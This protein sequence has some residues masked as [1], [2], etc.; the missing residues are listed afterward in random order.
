M[1]GFA[2]SSKMDEAAE[3]NLRRE[4][5][6]HD[7]M[8][9]ASGRRAPA[10]RA[11]AEKATSSF[12]AVESNAIDRSNDPGYTACCQDG[13]RRTRLERRVPGTVYT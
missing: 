7:P 4:E 6:G 8:A 12:F 5:R 10:E 13:S 11:N 2:V 1:V 3:E 9:A